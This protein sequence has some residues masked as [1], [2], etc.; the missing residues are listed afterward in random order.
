MCDLRILLYTIRRETARQ[1]KPF[2]MML[3][4]EA[5]QQTEFPYQGVFNPLHTVYRINYGKQI[6]N[7]KQMLKNSNKVKFMCLKNA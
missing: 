1:I 6:I 7:D 5:E 3:I 2:M 4:M